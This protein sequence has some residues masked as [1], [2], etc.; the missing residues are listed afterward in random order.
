MKKTITNLLLTALIYASL[1]IFM[2]NT[3][4]HSHDSQC[5]VYVLEQ[6]YFSADVIEPFKDLPLYLAF[7]LFLFTPSNIQLQVKKHFNIRAPPSL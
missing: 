2:H 3:F 1:H 4:D 6:L 5:S 7:L